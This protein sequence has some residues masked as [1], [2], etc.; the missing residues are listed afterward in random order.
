MRERSKKKRVSRRERAASMVEYALL[1]ALLT[2]VCIAG[3]RLFGQRAS[4][5]FS[6][7]GSE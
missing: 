2:T 7:V 6:T 3:I 1:I 4:T 5:T